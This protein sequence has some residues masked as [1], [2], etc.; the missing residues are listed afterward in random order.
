MKVRPRRS[1]KDCSRTAVW[2]DGVRTPFVK[3]FG[4]FG[5][6][7]CHELFAR[8]VQSLVRRLDFS[9][10]EIDEIQC[11]VVIPQT[12]HP[13]V[14]RDAVLELDLGDH[15]H[16]YTLNRACT[17]SIQTIANATKSIAFGEHQVVL[18]G[19]VESLSD[20]PIPYSDDARSFLLELSKAKSLGQRLGILSRL[21]LKHWIP[22]SPGLDEPLTGFSMGQHAE[23]MAKINSITRAEQDKFAV[24]SHSR[25]A[26][27]QKAG[28]FDQEVIPF[29]PG[30]HYSPA[31]KL[32]NLIRPDT[33]IEALSKLRPV[34]DRESGSITAGNASSLTDGASCSLIADEGFAKKLGLKP[35]TRIVDFVFV[36]VQPHP[37]LLLGPAV[38]IPMLLKKRGMTLE[39]VDLFE[40]HEAFAAQ[41]L[42]CLKVMK[43]RDF[44]QSRFG[45]DHAFGEIPEEKLNVNGGAIAI[46]HPF[47]AT[48]SRLV[49]TLSREL[50]RRQ[51]KFGLIA[52]CAA[53][54][55]SGAMLIENCN[56]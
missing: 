36:G 51:K 52:I 39:Q 17:S 45:D 26:Q 9:P 30:P 3:S 15:I 14:A 48:G 31:V 47:G 10:Q 22:K 21:K 35:V 8:T 7:G 55:M 46:G 34:F 41:V 24:R 33:T 44:M 37:Q 25:A 12:K 53:G 13:N 18:A 28:Y 2:I 20:V 43:S 50:A 4:A 40:I 32:D 49:S 56:A 1:D 19:G 23:M 42:S 16:G 54:G 27:A 6:T 11:G 29:F 38:A 5:K